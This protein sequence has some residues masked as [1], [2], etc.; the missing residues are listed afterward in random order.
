MLKIIKFNFSIV[1]RRKKGKT[2][3]GR[4]E[5]MQK[6]A[7]GEAGSCRV[8]ELIARLQEGG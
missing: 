1:N 3:C 5:S 2:I 4:I 7:V 8:V 6:I